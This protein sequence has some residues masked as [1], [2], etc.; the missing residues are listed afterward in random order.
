MNWLTRIKKIGENI[1]FNIQKKFPSKKEQA[2][3]PWIS[4]CSGPVLKSEIFND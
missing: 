1:K 2:N 3:S 4:C